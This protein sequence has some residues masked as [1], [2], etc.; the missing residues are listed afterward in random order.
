MCGGLPWDN[1]KEEKLINAVF[2]KPVIWDKTNPGH[3]K[4]TVVMRAWDEVE[5]TMKPFISN[6]C[7]EHFLVHCDHIC[8]VHSPTNNY[9]LLYVISH[10]IPT[11]IEVE[12]LEHCV[13]QGIEQVTTTALRLSSSEHQERLGSFRIAQ[14][15]VGPGQ[16][17]NSHWEYPGVTGAG[18]N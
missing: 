6:Y 13:Q 1:D 11:E 14:V 5:R 7:D 9:N 10:R 3:G 4:S 17:S 15:H 2:A 16:Q 8:L 18:A 12:N